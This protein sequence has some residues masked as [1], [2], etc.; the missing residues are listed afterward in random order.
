VFHARLLDDLMVASYCNGASD[1]LVL[2]LLHRWHMGWAGAQAFSTLAKE[3]QEILPGQQPMQQQQQEPQ[4]QL[5][6][7]QQ[8]Q[9]DVTAAPLT[10]IAA[11][12]AAAGGTD[13]A[14]QQ[15]HLKSA[16]SAV[17]NNPSR[18]A[19]SMKVAEGAAGDLAKRAMEEKRGVPVLMQVGGA[20]G[21][22][23]LCWCFVFVVCAWCVFLGGGDDHSPPM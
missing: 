8:Q 17:L 12:A 19:T 20:G 3:Q 16:A 11:A 15:A 23:G 22:G 21:G 2:Q 13:P 10:Q 7:Q 9:A 1:R 6:Q 5:W 4:K 18:A 14:Q